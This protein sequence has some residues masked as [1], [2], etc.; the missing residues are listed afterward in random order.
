LSHGEC[1]SGFDFTWHV[2]DFCGHGREVHVGK[3]DA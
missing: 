1:I 2:T 3:H